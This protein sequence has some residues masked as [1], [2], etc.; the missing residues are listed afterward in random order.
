MA[1]PGCDTSVISSA[2]QLVLH[3]RCILLLLLKLLLASRQDRVHGHVKLAQDNVLCLLPV[4]L[5]TCG[6]RLA[7]DEIKNL[8]TVQGAVLETIPIETGGQDDPAVRA[9]DAVDDGLEVLSVDSEPWIMASG[10]AYHLPR[11]IRH[12]LCQELIDG[13]QVL[14]PRLLVGRVLP[15]M[16]RGAGP[17]VEPL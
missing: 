13:L 9:R 6:A 15:I 12:V 1:P 16:P 11:L 5:Q 2:P 17:D 8:E 14:L 10:A 7:C 3:F 4:P